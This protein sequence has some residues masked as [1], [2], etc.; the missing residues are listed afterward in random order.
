MAKDLNVTQIQ[1][2]VQKKYAAVSQSAEGRFQYPT[3]RAGV[4]ALG[5]DL[6]LVGQLPDEVVES[7]CGVGNPF[8][9]GAFRPGETILDVGCGAGFDLIVASYLVGP[10]GQVC[11]ID[12]TPEMVERA[13][14]NL[15]RA[16][17]SNGQV[18]RAGS[19]AIPYADGTFDVVISNGVLNLSPLK[20]TS[21]EEIYR[22]LKPHG[23]LQFA[24]IV[25]KA[26]LPAEV[27]TSLEAWSE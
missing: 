17:V 18:H 9:L 2:A 4:E 25:V 23:R 1:E 27:A 14:M 8:S 21:F 19:E 12:L 20:E 15:K 11:G 7:F 24:D 10:S 3:G 5:Y 16:G 26:D 6:S 13:R 22:V